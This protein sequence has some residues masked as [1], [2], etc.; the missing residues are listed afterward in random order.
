M[1]RN[2]T[3]FVWRNDSG[4]DYRFSCQFYRNRTGRL[5]RLWSKWHGMTHRLR[6]IV[7]SFEKKTWLKLLGYTTEWY[8]AFHQANCFIINDL[9]M[10]IIKTKDHVYYYTGAYHWSNIAGGAGGD[11]KSPILRV[12]RQHLPCTFVGL[13]RKTG[14]TVSSCPI[15]ANVCCRRK[16]SRSMCTSDR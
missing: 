15:K 3:T 12:G 4:I 2:P 7:D 14:K 13:S 8:S 16:L 5:H 1:N 9:I 6:L 10:G 11:G